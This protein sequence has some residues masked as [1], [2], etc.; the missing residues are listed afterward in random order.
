MTL[1][2]PNISD[3]GGSLPD[4]PFHQQ[5]AEG[6]TKAHAL[7]ANAVRSMSAMVV[8]RIAQTARYVNQSI[9]TFLH[10]HNKKYLIFIYTS[11]FKNKIYH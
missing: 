10:N 5:I 4:T 2:P 11:F 6:M 7:R 9:V 3:I 1:A 8:M